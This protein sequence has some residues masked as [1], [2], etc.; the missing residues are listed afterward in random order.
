M[1]YCVGYVCCTGPHPSTYSSSLYFPFLRISI[2]EIL[3]PNLS[4]ISDHIVFYYHI[5]FFLN[6]KAPF[7]FFDLLV[8]WQRGSV[9]WFHSPIRAVVRC[10]RI[11]H[12]AHANKKI[13]LSLVTMKLIND[14]G[15]LKRT[16]FFPCKISSKQQC[17]SRPGL[18][19]VP[20]FFSHYS[21]WG[22]GSSIY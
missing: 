21:T 3:W 5:I 12:F 10:T 14:K 6:K 19:K 1:L 15:V 8:K 11:R 2:M 18:L 17:R 16:G 4:C 22:I 9:T 13:N 20:A 7:I